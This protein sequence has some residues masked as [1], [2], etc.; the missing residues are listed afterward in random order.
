LRAYSLGVRARVREGDS[1]AIP[2]FRQALE[3]DPAFALAHARLSVV[4]E[5]LGDRPLAR[6]EVQRAYE[7]REKVS[8][9]ERL[10]IVSRFHDI[11]SGDA[12]KRIEML[13]LMSETFPRDFAARNNLGVAYLEMGRVER[14]V[15]QFRAAVSL[16]PD[17]RLPNMNLANTLVTLGRLDEA[18]VAFER[19]LAIGD[20]GDTR[21]GAYLRA[22][23]AGDRAEMERQYE[24]GRRGAEP[25]LLSTARAQTLAYEGRLAA[26]RRSFDEAIGDA[27]QAKR[28]GAVA[29][30]WLLR[31]YFDVQME[32]REGARHAAAQALAH[33]GDARNVLQAATVLALAGEPAQ[34]AAL[35]APL[36][37]GPRL[38]TITR[39]V[40]LALARAAIALANGDA[41]EAHRQVDRSAAYD[42]RYPELTWVRGLAH[43]AAR[44]RAAVADFRTLVEHPWRG[45]GVIAP[46]MRLHLARA[47]MRSGDPTAAR[48]A[49]D[50]FLTS[51]ANADPDAVLV[52]AA[53]AERAAVTAT[54]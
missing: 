31:A 13:R 20:S 36:E 35:V 3:L 52:K 41:V 38:D 22:Y 29:R 54:N 19:T 48:A 26:A 6:E 28:R 2:F 50:H 40:H 24:A 5:N 43:L 25:W 44:D 12:D 30:G 27:A 51:W 17:Q 1:P 53:R 18:R 42:D 47:L 9:Y 39:D 33:D 45:G 15:E 10:Y 23:Y 46:A 21:A 7:L 32:D 34:A 49:Y 4:Y 37:A 14:A 11:V 8:E 16:A